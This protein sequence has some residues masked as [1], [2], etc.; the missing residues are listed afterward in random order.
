MSLKDVSGL[1]SLKDFLRSNIIQLLAATFSRR[2]SASANGCFSTEWAVSRPSLQVQTPTCQQVKADVLPSWPVQ[3]NC[4]ADWALV[5]EVRLGC[6]RVDC[7]RH[8][9][10]RIAHSQLL[11]A[12]QLQATFV[13]WCALAKEV[14]FTV[15]CTLP[16]M[17]PNI[18]EVVE[19]EFRVTQRDDGSWLLEQENDEATG[20][21]LIFSSTEQ[22][23]LWPEL[24]T[25][26][27]KLL[28][29]STLGLPIWRFPEFTLMMK[30]SNMRS[31]S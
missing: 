4:L 22:F 8:L 2:D 20:W 27:G 31:S 26:V 5:I 23:D 9:N 3:L 12:S 19:G 30:P 29:V 24:V 14:E 15:F 28:G 11:A 6:V 18:R 25:I 10:V 7:T 13:E 16:H 1:S 17:H 21:D